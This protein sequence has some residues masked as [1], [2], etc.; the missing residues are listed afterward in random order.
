MKTLYLIRHAQ[1]AAN[2]GGTSLPDR[3]IPLSTA[4]TQQAAELVC[5]LPVNRRVFVSEMRRTHETAAPYCAR[6]GIRPE[7]LPCLNEFSYLPFTAVQ[8][9]DASARKP[10][11]E[12]YWQRT[13]P[14]FRAGSGADTF[15]EFDGRV[16][17]FLLNVWPILPHGSLLFGHGIW[18]ALLAWRLS[19][20]RAESGADMAAFRA[21]QSSLHVTNA[22]VWRLDG[23]ETSAE[24][25]HC[26][27]ENATE[28]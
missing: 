21:F 9:L 5:R 8:G 24:S 22:S 23:T 28:F 6:H 15:A 26:L 7:I 18:M 10:L 14:H 17:D 25:L 2:A 16:S 27:P 20:N 11:A 13:D 12:A 4:G 1:S 19:G 3:E